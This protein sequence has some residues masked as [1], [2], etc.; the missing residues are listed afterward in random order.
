MGRF[1]VE[2]RAAGSAGAFGLEP[3]T[4]AVRPTADIIAPQRVA[5]GGPRAYAVDALRGL[6]ILVMVLGETKPYGV[7]PAWMYHAQEPPPSHEENLH[8]A[9]LTF[10][11]LVFPFF[12]FTIGV[13][14]PLALS[15]RL[16]KGASRASIVRGALTRGGLLVFLAFFREH[17]ARVPSLVEP[18]NTAMLVGLAA[19]P[20]LFAIFV[21]LPSAWPRLP[22]LLVRAAGWGS[23]VT[24]FALV[25]FPDGTTFSPQRYDIILAVAA[26][27]VVG[28]TALWMITRRHPWLRL[29]IIA[30]V[31]YFQPPYAQYLVIALPGT[32]IGDVLLKRL[33][34]DAPMEIAARIGRWSHGRAG[35]LALGLTSFVPLLLVGVQMRYVTETTIAA[36][37]LG[38]G[39]MA[40]ARRPLSASEHMVTDLIVWGLP[41]LLL[42]LVFDPIEGGTQK[43]PPTLAWMCQSVGLGILLIA[44]FTIVIDI[45]SKRW[46]RLLVDNGQNPM[47]AYVGY[48]TLVLPVVALTGLQLTL[49][50]Q[51]PG[52]WLLFGWA[53]LLT[54]V[55]AVIVRAF[56]CQRI[57]WRT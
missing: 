38:L 55:V 40:L 9:G 35:L 32:I 4:A 24:M 7:L 47:I 50:R 8:L 10:P 15:A 11:D 13:A 37:I 5:T 21:R 23:A 29:P 17:F 31:M 56:T 36:G 44:A 33:R 43:V 12:L 49:E 48:A 53:V 42:G 26:V 39:V 16:R 20:V 46:L 1:F 45:L 54:L 27:C 14:I 28:A 6:G 2:Y 19:F 57:F 41:W 22:R 30:A 52:P 3:P 34:P 25:R 18:Q 51:E